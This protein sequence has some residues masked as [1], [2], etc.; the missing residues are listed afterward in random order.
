MSDIQKVQ[1]DT[2]KLTGSI[3]VNK[4]EK[5]GDSHEKTNKKMLTLCDN[6]KDKEEG[7]TITI[8]EDQIITEDDSIY[9][10]YI[11]ID[12]RRDSTGYLTLKKN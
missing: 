2:V 9:L 1:C 12:G 4:V 6:F 5:E 3:N 7:E 11:Y 8:L 10:V